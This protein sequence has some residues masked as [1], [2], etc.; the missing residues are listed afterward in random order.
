MSTA[1]GK[2]PVS[3][4]RCGKNLMVPAS[5]AGKQGRCPTC[6]NVFLITA[7]PDVEED[8]EPLPD[9]AP[10]ESSGLAPLAGDP[11]AAAATSGYTLQP[12]QPQQYYPSYQ[13]SQ[14]PQHALANQYM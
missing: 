6:Q 9:L 4:P 2:I 8:L 13:Q 14:A 3:C 12:T 10:L 11:F 5:F 7:P 1:P